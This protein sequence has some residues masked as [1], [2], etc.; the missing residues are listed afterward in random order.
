[1][2]THEKGYPDDN[3]IEELAGHT[4]PMFPGIPHRFILMGRWPDGTKLILTVLTNEPERGYTYLKEKQRQHRWIAHR[5]LEE[6]VWTGK[7]VLRDY[8]LI[9]TTS[10]DDDEIPF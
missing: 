1:M 8:T 6:G 3:F 7:D 4:V 9:R 10:V 2:P 5:R